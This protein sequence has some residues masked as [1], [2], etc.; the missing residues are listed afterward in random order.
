MKQ[1]KLTILSVILA[2]S[3]AQNAIGQKE[4]E[5]PKRSYTVIKENPITPVKNQ[6]R[7][8]TCWD[9]ATVG[10]FEGEILRKTGKTPTYYHSH[11]RHLA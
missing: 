6:S 7:S 4:N 10:F 11:S 9:F 5:S 8:G 3:I 2:A 1:C